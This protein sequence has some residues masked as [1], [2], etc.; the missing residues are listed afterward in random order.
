MVGDGINDA[1]SLTLAD[2]G[3]SISSGTDIARSSADVIL[4]KND[5][6]K[7]VDFLNISKKTLRNIKQN[8]FWAFLY[9]VCMIPIAMGL[10]VSFNLEINPMIACISMIISSLFV[11]FN[12]LR[13]RNV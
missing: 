12:A 3:I 13:L 4:M 9:N 5:L 1:P 6:L 7:I 2:I 10:F 11:I 8:L